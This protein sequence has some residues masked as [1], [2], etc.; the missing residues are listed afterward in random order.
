MISSIES[1]RKNIIVRWR[2]T[3]T[4]YCY[5]LLFLFVV[6]TFSNIILFC[7]GQEQQAEANR[8]AN[9]RGGGPATVMSKA[10]P[11]DNNNSFLTEIVRKEEMLEIIVLVMGEAAAF[12]TWYD[13]LKVVDKD[14]TNLVLV[15]AS[16]DQ[17]VANTSKFHREKVD[18]VQDGEFVDFDTIYIKGTTWTQGRNLLAAEALRKEKLHGK[19]FDYWYFIDDDVSFLRCSQ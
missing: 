9:L 14:T 17:K 1:K 5:Q 19:T 18:S 13:N 16:Y 7:N 2:W 4:F 15:Y 3:A 8:F 6:S 12:E 11:N 10:S